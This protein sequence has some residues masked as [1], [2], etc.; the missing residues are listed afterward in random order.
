MNILRSMCSVVSGERESL[1]AGPAELVYA[2][3]PGN[4]ERIDQQAHL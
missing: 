1:E 2:P 3:T 4:D